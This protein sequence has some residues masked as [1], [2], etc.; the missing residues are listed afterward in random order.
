MNSGAI[1]AA[2]AL[3]GFAIYQL[4]RQRAA[5]SL[6][7]QFGQDNPPDVPDVVGLDAQQPDG[8]SLL[9]VLAAPVQSIAQTVDQFT[10]GAFHVSGMSQVTPALLQNA[11]VQ[12]ML[13][14]IRRGESS[15]DDDAYLMLYGGGYFDDFAD[16]PRIKVTAG[17]YTSTAAG[18]Y[19]FLSSTWDETARIVGLRDFSP[20]SQDLAAVARMVYRRALDDVLRGDLAAA[21]PKLGKEWASLPGSPYGQPTISMD[22]ARAT[23]TQNGGAFA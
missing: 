11:N 8:V 7:D 14:V 22:V 3:G 9:D 10:G 18:A 12:A 2:L 1:V 6:W 20:E 5:V 21:L 4:S 19:Q 17:G 13:K 16:H 15:M 23:Y